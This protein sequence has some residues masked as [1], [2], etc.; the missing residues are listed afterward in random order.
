MSWILTH[1]GA[2]FHLAGPEALVEANQPV[3]IEDIAHALAHINRFTGHTSQP[4]S[5][6]Q[7]SLL[8]YALALWH[9]ASPAAHR[10]ALLHDAH[11]AYVGDVSS[12]I[13]CALGPAWAAFEERI[14]KRVRSALH[15]GTAMVVFREFIKK[16][17]LVALLM[18]RNYFM[19][20]H[21]A[22]VSTTWAAECDPCV[23]R[24]WRDA[25]DA[26]MVFRLQEL[27]AMTPIQVRREFLIAD[28]AL[29]ARISAQ[30]GGSEQERLAL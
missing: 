25:I 17:D 21:K 27:L 15:I 20:G 23:K 12:P 4:W 18:E 13:K 10:A 7:H 8:V 29:L 9:T 19:P 14:E 22:D 16:L 26:D 5:V 2:E 6:G 28:G 30:I 11:E 3:L 24:L 1:S